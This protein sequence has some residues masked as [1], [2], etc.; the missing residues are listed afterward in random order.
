MDVRP[1]GE[2]LLRSIT[3]ENDPMGVLFFAKKKKDEIKNHNTLGKNP[4][5]QK[6]VHILSV[7]QDRR[8]IKVSR[9]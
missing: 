3:C 4:R 2:E 1:K 6:G 8:M 5:S 9:L 7:H